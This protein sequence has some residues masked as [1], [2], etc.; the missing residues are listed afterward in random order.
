MSSKYEAPGGSGGGGSGSVTSVAVT[1]SDGIEVDSGSPITSSGTI[2]L[3]V[4]KTTLLAHIN[5]ADGATANT[6]TIDGTLTAGRVPFAQDSNTLTDDGNLTFDATNELLAVTKVAAQSVFAVNNQTV[7][8]IPAGTP[9]FVEAVGSGGRPNVEPADADDTS[10]MPSIG[11]VTNQIS[12]AN[13]G[14]AATNGQIN[15][16]DGSASG[17]LVDGAGSAYTLQGTDI[18]KTLY[19]SPTAGKLTTTKPTGESDAIQNVGKIVDISG[20][21][22]KMQVSNIGRSNDV[23][24]S[25]TVTGTT[26]L[27]KGNV[28]TGDNSP[29]ASAADAGKY[30]YR[31]SGE[32]SAFT[33]PTITNVGEQYVLLNNS[34]SALTI[35]SAQTVVGSTS[36]PD[37]QSATIICVA[38]A[39]WFVVG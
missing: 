11:I 30:F 18:G 26:T 31:A 3:G 20:S 1:G 22:F 16:L 10:K 15:G 21:N 24:N 32:T 37:G 35:S 5:V 25:F 36:I 19:V 27:A 8:A 7:S 29:G 17:I 12:S 33:L 4:D 9:V 23:P 34:G 38:A 13:T 14:Y 39:T 2:A 28:A 6:G